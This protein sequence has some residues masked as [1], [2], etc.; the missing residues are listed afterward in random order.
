MM[1][2]RAIK[3]VLAAA[4]IVLGQ[5]LP[6]EAALAQG[7]ASIGISPAESVIGAAA[8][9]VDVIVNSADIG[10]RGAECAISFTPGLLECTDIID[11]DY[12]DAWNPV[13]IGPVATAAIH[14]DT[15][16][17]DDI[18][19]FATGGNAGEGV[20]GEG[21]LFT[22]YFRALGNGTANITIA[23]A[24]I[25]DLNGDAITPLDIINGTVHIELLP[26]LVVT[27]ISP[28]WIQ[29]SSTYSVNYTVAN[30]G[31]ADAGQFT[32]I[33]AVDGSQILNE[34]IESLGAGKNVTLHYAGPVHISGTS[35]EANNSLEISWAADTI[36]DAPSMLAAE[37]QGDH[38]VKLTW[39][40]NSNNEDGF[41]IEKALNS[42]FSSGFS[43]ITVAADGVIYIDT[44]TIE[45]TTYYY[46]VYAYN[47]MGSS[48]PSNT[49]SIL[50]AKM[51][52][53]PSELAL[54]SSD[55]SEIRIKWTDSSSNEDGFYVERAE[56]S[57]FDKGLR[58]FKLGKNS[59][60]TAY[61]TDSTFKTNTVYYYRV[62]AFKDTYYTEYT[63]AI[64]VYVVAL[65][66]APSGL[67]Y[68]II[69]AGEGPW[70]WVALNWVDNS[71][72]ELGFRIERAINPTFTQ[73]LKCFY[74]MDNILSYVD[75]TAL[76]YYEYYY[77]IFAYNPSGDSEPSQVI[78]VRT[79]ALPG[80]PALLQV[81]NIAQREISLSWSD[82]S[83]DEFGFRV[84]RASSTD[85][86]Q[87]LVKFNVDADTT[88][89]TDRRVQFGKP[90][91]YRVVA[92]NLGGESDYSNTVS[93][94]LPE[95]PQAPSKLKAVL[96]DAGNIDLKWQDN[97]GNEAGF[98]IERAS[99]RSFLADIELSYVGPDVTSYV[100]TD[101]PATPFVYYR[102]YAYNT[103]VTYNIVAESRQSNITYVQ[104]TGAAQP[105]PEWEVAAVRADEIAM[106]D[107]S[108]IIDGDG[109][110]TRSVSCLD[111]NGIRKISLE[112]G[113]LII[114]KYGKPVRR[115][116]VQ[117]VDAIS[118][119]LSQ[120]RMVGLPRV[121]RPFGK[122]APPLTLILERHASI[123]GYVY[124]LEPSGA[125]FDV[126]LSLTLQYDPALC[127][128]DIDKKNIA[129]AYYDSIN[130]NWVE[131]ASE[132]D[133][134][135]NTVTA[136]ISH[137]SVYG[138]LVKGPPIIQVWVVGLGILLIMGA[139]LVVV[140][141]VK[142]RRRQLLD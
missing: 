90:Y 12:Y 22:L 40:D 56:N 8:F 17:I 110:L 89:F 24:A 104:L 6:P 137:F 63:N 124:D 112:E 42:S 120:N 41:T 23:S 15:G 36:P 19:I 100:D 18:G 142:M 95:Q 102:L 29:V 34:P 26:D 133:A 16:S 51:P 32:T 122:S 107:L 75:K 81:A 59:G 101:K 61:Y 60:S 116:E 117:P 94:K 130:G 37:I 96:D 135:N 74:V 62:R 111:L 91:C 66:E 109:F 45:E 98:R 28:S 140:Y 27:D 76:G 108:G 70:V 129:I 25:G 118:L 53:A 21:T 138:V 4:L 68:T 134:R 80:T 125:T 131:V 48:N 78:H 127:P 1:S 139:G 55:A 43:S 99:D 33:L 82:N 39:Q 20:Y 5:L 57:K 83:S 7:G 113:T 77:R 38:Y 141:F 46:R 106:L 87:D 47:E 49:V 72:T 115:I 31:G 88:T 121:F 35:D 44:A 11:G 9:T 65:E 3:I 103:Q 93:V 50:A 136:N 14:N 10:S 69:D 119:S 105:T 58:K 85:F 97:S 132:V 79:Q 126:P 128:P 13:R 73:D 92:F 64:Q 71:D 30:T 114:D 2:R 52:D 84:E 67:E 54:V 86:S 123:V